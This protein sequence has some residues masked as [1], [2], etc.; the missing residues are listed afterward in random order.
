[1]RERQRDRERERERERG[2]ERERERDLGLPPP[3]VEHVQDLVT[4]KLEHMFKAPQV[5]LN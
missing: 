2:G 1:V 3:Q 5:Q 4:P